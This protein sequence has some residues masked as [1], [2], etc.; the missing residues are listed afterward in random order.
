MRR[1]RPPRRASP[2]GLWDA[3]NAHVQ[4]GGDWGTQPLDWGRA[5]AGPRLEAPPTP[6]LEPGEG[7]RKRGGGQPAALPPSHPRPTAPRSAA[8]R[9]PTGARRRSRSESLLRGPGN[10]AQHRGPRKAKRR[11]PTSA[12]SPRAAVS[13]PMGMRSLGHRQGKRGRA[14]AAGNCSPRAPAI[15]RSLSPGLAPKEPDCISH[16]A[17]GRLPTSGRARSGLD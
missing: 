8:R 14:C 15:H 5:A 4:A 9:L 7:G 10:H 3:R 13:S 16:S 6:G 12:R 17:A 2:A 1:E 11:R